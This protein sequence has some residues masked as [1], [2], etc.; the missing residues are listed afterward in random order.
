MSKLAVRCAAQLPS[1]SPGRVGVSHCHCRSEPL[2]SEPHSELRPCRYAAKRQ[3]AARFAV[4]SPHLQHVGSAMSLRWPPGAGSTLSAHPRRRQAAPRTRD[5]PRRAAQSMGGW[6]AA[7]SPQF[8]ALCRPPQAPLALC[9][10]LLRRRLQLF[11]T[12]ALGSVLPG[13]PAWRWAAPPR[14]TSARRCTAAPPHRCTCPLLSTPLHSRAP[15]SGAIIVV[16]AGATHLQELRARVSADGTWA[17]REPKEFTLI[18]TLT[19]T[20]KG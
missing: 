15:S 20:T 17:A 16:R 4:G 13:A 19:L 18:L 9:R 7:T 10:R 14:C 1:A 5:E 3:P 2:Y 8:N 11:L 6:D 12:F